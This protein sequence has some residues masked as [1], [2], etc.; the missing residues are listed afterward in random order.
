[1]NH[2]S[3]PS[4]IKWRTLLGLGFMY[5]AIGFDWQ[6][7]WGILFLLW[8]VPDLM[9]GVTYFIEPIEKQKYPILYW[10]IMASWILMGLYSVSTLFFPE[11]A[12]YA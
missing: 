8:V 9:Q 2:S 1:M 7:A 12:Y 6:W 11:W 5:L 10:L 4:T 3:S